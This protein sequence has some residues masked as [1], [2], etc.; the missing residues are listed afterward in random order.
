MPVILNWCNYDPPR[1]VLFAPGR[2]FIAAPSSFHPQSAIIQRRSA[3]PANE[4]CA[5]EEV[6]LEIVLNELPDVPKVVEGLA[7]FMQLKPE[8]LGMTSTHDRF[9]D[10]DDMVLLSQ[11]HSLRIRQK[12]ENVFAGNQVRLTYKFP[13]EQH[14]KLFIR[15]ERKLTLTEPDYDHVLAVLSSLAQGVGGQELTTILV[16]DELAREANLGPKGARLNLSI[17]QCSYCLPDDSRRAD[18]V[19]FELESHGIGRERVLAAGEWV[20]ANVGGR[21]A[22]QPK[23]ARGLRLLGQL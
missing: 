7:E 1:Q 16:I 8:S 2:S 10:T 4:E 19:V 14:E 15:R 21:I 22:K 17:D 13:L 12:L 23:Y 3:M 18:E 11:D 9:V 20:L 6:E 5:M